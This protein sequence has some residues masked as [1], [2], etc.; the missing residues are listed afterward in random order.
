MKIEAA[1]DEQQV[2]Q[3]GPSKQELLEQ[4]VVS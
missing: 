2:E 4:Q 1:A 3:M